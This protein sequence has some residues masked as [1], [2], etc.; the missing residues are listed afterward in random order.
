VIAALVLSN[1][2][3]NLKPVSDAA[4]KL[5][6]SPNGATHKYKVT[7]VVVN[8]TLVEQA[9]SSGSTAPHR[10]VAA[11]AYCA[12]PYLYGRVRYAQW[13]DELKKFAPGLNVCTFYGNGK[14]KEAGLKA[15]RSMDVLIT[16]PHMNM[17]SH[18]LDNMH[19][20]RLVVRKPRHCSRLPRAAISRS[21]LAQPSRAA[22]SRSR[23]A[24]PSRA[25]V[26][27]SHLAR[28]SLPLARVRP[29]D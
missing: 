10:S 22:V 21:H 13:A 26:S 27:R 14:K 8:N 2:A 25:A 4:F 15:L 23:L 17:P 28:S 12:H 16:T 19:I 6:M 3:A 9:S 5:L 1:P 20:H 18:L 11:R 29:A 24:Q 7:V